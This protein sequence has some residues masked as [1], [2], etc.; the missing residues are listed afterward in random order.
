MRRTLGYPES[1]HCYE[2]F[3]TESAPHAAAVVRPRLRPAQKHRNSHRTPHQPKRRRMSDPELLEDTA[4]PSQ[5]RARQRN[6]HARRRRWKGARRCNVR[7]PPAVPGTA[8]PHA[9]RYLDSRRAPTPHPRTP[10]AG[11][12]RTHP[13]P[14]C[15]QNVP[16]NKVFRI[17]QAGALDSGNKIAAS[18][19]GMG[20]GGLAVDA[21]AIGCLGVERRVERFF[22]YLAMCVVVVV[23]FITVTCTANGGHWVPP[24]GLQ[25][26]SLPQPWLCRA[27]KVRRGGEGDACVSM[28]TCNIKIHNREHRF[29]NSVPISG[30]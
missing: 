3:C 4:S 14:A 2:P 6:E 29:P 13:H 1:M 22:P 10:H 19:H 5:P 30:P 21:M 12:A 28:E 20:S 23:V 17:C 18:A 24:G 9:R 15:T 7:S 27:P 11:T 8:S 16:G 26:Y 25:A